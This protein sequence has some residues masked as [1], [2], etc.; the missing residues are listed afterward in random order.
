MN[1]GDLIESSDITSQVK[2]VVIDRLYHE[3]MGAEGHKEVIKVLMNGIAF[4][5]ELKDKEW[6]NPTK[7][8]I[9]PKNVVLKSWGYYEDIFRSYTVVFKR[10]TIAPGQKTSYQ[11]HDFRKEFWL[12]YSGSGVYKQGKSRHEYGTFLLKPGVTV[13]IYPK[14]THQIVNDGNSDLIIYEMQFGACSEDDICRLEN[15]V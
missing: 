5:A 7:E 4:Q 10:L 14:E 9:P 11:Y 2:S 6:L 1:N 15:P 12:V 3:V 13:L 8:A